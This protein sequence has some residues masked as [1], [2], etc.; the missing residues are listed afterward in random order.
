LLAQ[1]LAGAGD[2]V[3]RGGVQRRDLVQHQL[4]VGQRLRHD[5]GRAQGGDRGG[6]RAVHALGQ[7]EVVL[8]HQVQRQVALHVHR[9]LGEQVGDLLACV[10]QHVLAHHARLFRVAGVQLRRLG[11][12]RR[13][14]LLADVDVFLQPLHQAPQVGLFLLDGGVVAQQLVL[15]ALEAVDDGVQ[16]LWL[17]WNLSK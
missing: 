10:E 4:L 9:H 17:D 15:A 6:G 5:D 7:F 8:A 11:L 1:Q 14:Q 13:V 2:Q 3:A 16:V 12:Q